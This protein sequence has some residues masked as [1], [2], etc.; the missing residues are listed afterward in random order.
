MTGGRAVP[1][2][3]SARPD[4]SIIIPVHGH[5]AAT[6]D[7]LESLA[8]LESRHSAE[9]IVVD[10]CSPDDTA[11]RLSGWAGIRAVRTPEN[12]GF[13]G[14]CN[15]GAAQAAGDV[16][17][18]LNNDTVVHPE[19]LDALLDTLASDQ[20]IGLVGSLL[21]GADGAVQ[22]SGG[23]VWQDATGWN[24]G[25]GW[26]ADDARVRAV[27]DVDYCSGASIAVRANVFH[28]LGGFDTKYAPAYYEDTDLCFA[29]RQ[30]GF[31]VVVQPESVV[32]HAEG[33]THGQDD[34]GGL[35]RFQA[36]NRHVFLRKWR[37]VL[38]GHG[39]MREAADLWRARHRTGGGLV[40][41]V[42]ANVPTPDR[43]AGSRRMSGIIDILLAMGRYVVFAPAE[44]Q[45]IQPYARELERRG[46]TVLVTEEDQQR[47]FREAGGLL[48][49]VLLC[50]PNVA[51]QYLECV[52]S[53]APEALLIYDTVDL[54]ALRQH[55]RASFE[56]SAEQARRAD[57]VWA[58]ESA[59]MRAADVCLVVS[60]A[61]QAL[62]AEIEPTVDVR[63]L[64]TIHRPVVTEPDPAGRGGVLFVGGYQHF[65]NVDAA[66]WAAQEIMP[67]V[68]STSPG[69]TLDLIGSHMPIEVTALDGDGVN[70]VG[71][72]ADLEPVYAG[73]RVA[74]APLRFG[75][76]IKGKVA[77]AIEYGV[78]VV[79]TSVAA[80][81]LDL[82]DGADVLIA[83]NA[84]DFAKAIIRLIDDDELWRTLAGAGQQLLEARFSADAARGVLVDLLDGPGRP[85]RRSPLR[86]R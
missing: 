44:R 83:D 53:Y 21:L 52:Y 27:R 1:V 54:H 66:R 55:R 78:P 69:A 71:W 51:W 36:V 41:I 26:A 5:W 76:G 19:W 7:C 49:A 61:E 57:L 11:E 17:V 40:L 9:I 6:A 70:A 15:L 35:K 50:R 38:D 85:V 23:I 34:T 84:D 48:E 28:Q 56:Q 62:L 64:S 74:I 32:T 47:F 82:T 29:V 25:R 60:R 59:A 12:L 37:R 31:R 33:L 86:G 13:V 67:L 73:A 4:A 30:A 42:D 72:V 8:A 63:V 18:F 24:Y 20:R 79:I 80:E 77:E 58:K 45:A 16:L 68:R 10:D 75:A 65:P 14:A 46:V 2:A 3:P 81:G 39:S 43:D 22:E